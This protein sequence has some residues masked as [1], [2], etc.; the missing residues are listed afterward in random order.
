MV[1]FTSDQLNQW[2]FQSF[3]DPSFDTLQQQTSR[4]LDDAAR[5]AGYVEMQRQWDAAANTVWLA[6]PQVLYAGRTGLAP[7]L[8]VD[9]R[10]LAW[11]FREAG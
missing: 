3:S 9:G 4:T 6:W 7:S 1:W 8:R 5:Q 2:N 10:M 11:N